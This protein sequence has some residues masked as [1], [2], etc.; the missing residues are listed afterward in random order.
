MSVTVG[1]HRA[2]RLNGP[3]F[4][5]A[6]II[7][8]PD[9][10]YFTYDKAVEV[11][12]DVFDAVMT[13]YSIDASD[14]SDFEPIDTIEFKRTLQDYVYTEL[15]RHKREPHTSNSNGEE[16]KGLDSAANNT[17]AV[18]DIRKAVTGVFPTDAELAEL[19]D[20]IHSPGVVI[21]VT[22]VVLQ[23][24][25]DYLSDFYTHM[26]EEHPFHVERHGWDEVEIS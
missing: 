5:E 26:S 22:R 21:H 23:S 6:V 24:M 7:P 9:E 3:L 18:T 19:P 17:K 2:I 11:V 1:K 12:E 4:T 13:E 25:F 16:S 14:S 8:A 15:V 10:Q 20:M